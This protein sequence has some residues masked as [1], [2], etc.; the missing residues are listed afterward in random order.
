MLPAGSSCR[1]HPEIDLPLALDEPSE[2]AAGARS[3]GLARL[4]A[5]HRSRMKLGAGLQQLEDVGARDDSL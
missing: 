5:G 1:G 3:D 2:R 4:W